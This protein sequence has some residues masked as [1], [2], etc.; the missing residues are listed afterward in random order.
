MNGPRTRRYDV[1]IT[2]DGSPLTGP[3]EFAVAVEQAASTG[4]QRGPDRRDEPHRF[5]NVGGMR[6]GIEAI[7][8]TLKGQLDLE[9]H[10]GRTTGKGLRPRRPAPPAVA[11]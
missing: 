1:T 4:S 3:A 9:R 2:K 10:G 11:R 6:Q 7:I 8:D 5:G